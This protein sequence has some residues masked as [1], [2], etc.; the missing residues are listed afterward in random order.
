MSASN[1]IR[2][3]QL[4]LFTAVAAFGISVVVFG[5]WWSPHPSKQLDM[6]ALG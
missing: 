5:H 1:I 3:V 2:I 4:T 6:D